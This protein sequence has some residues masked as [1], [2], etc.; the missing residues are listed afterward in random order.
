MLSKAAS[1][2]LGGFWSRAGVQLCSL[3]GREAR[4]SWSQ[5]PAVTPPR[6]TCSRNPARGE[7]AGPHLSAANGASVSLNTAKRD[8]G[9][10]LQW[11]AAGGNSGGSEVLRV[12]NAISPLN[13]TKRYQRKE[14]IGFGSILFKDFFFFSFVNGDVMALKTAKENKGKQ[15]KSHFVK[16]F[17]FWY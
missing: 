6:L 11:A 12:E 15:A 14:I 8:Y 5:S 16:Y 10:Q 7:A 13:I 9:W 17:F 3:G 1:V 4:L 2:G